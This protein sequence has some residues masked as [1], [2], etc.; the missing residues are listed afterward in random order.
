MR[1][2]WTKSASLVLQRQHDL[3][4]L[5]VS[6]YFQCPSSSNVHQLNFQSQSTQ[7]SS[8]SS[9]AHLTT[10]AHSKYR[11]LMD[12]YAEEIRPILVSFFELSEICKS[13]S[14]VTSSALI[15]AV[16]AENLS[17]RFLPLTFEF[18]SSRLQFVSQPLPLPIAAAHHPSY[19]RRLTHPLFLGSKTHH[20]AVIGKSHAELVLTTR[21]RAEKRTLQLLS[22]ALLTVE[23]RHHELRK[24]F[25]SNVPPF[26]L[27][28]VSM[29]LQPFPST[30]DLVYNSQP[31]EGLLHLGLG[32]DLDVLKLDYESERMIGHIR[33]SILPPF[34]FLADALSVPRLQNSFTGMTLSQAETRT[35]IIRPS[36]SRIPQPQK[37]SLDLRRSKCGSNSVRFSTARRR[38]GRPSIFSAFG[39]LENSINC[40]SF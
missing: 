13:F 22:S 5:R 28:T 3:R 1:Q 15:N 21:I 32:K 40:V 19:L 29:F 7:L 8:K 31:V 17:V 10:L 6:V 18:G 23:N 39:E 11:D 25:T 26:S 9:T 33:T 35:I 34:A 24:A 4:L 30:L 37:Q 38:T 2:S 36:D 12:S 16:H 20:D 14:I 27:K